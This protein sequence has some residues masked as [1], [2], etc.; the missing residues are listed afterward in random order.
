M[1]TSF[2]ILYP[3]IMTLVWIIG[4]VFYQ[5]SRSSSA[6]VAA[7]TVGVSVLVPCFNEQSHLAQ[8]V[9]S[10]ADQAHQNLEVILIDDASTDDTWQLMKQLQSDFPQLH[11]KTV[12]QRQN[13]GKAAALNAGLAVANHDYVLC[14][15]A[16]SRIE[17]SAT[18]HL[19]ATLAAHPDMGA[20]TGRP[21]VINR[22]R[23][24]EKMQAMEYIAIIDLIKRSQMFF[25]GNILTISGVL[26]MFRKDA[27]TAIN[28]WDP[29][30]QTEDIDI[31]WRLSQAGYCVGYNHRAI[32]WILVPFTLRALLKQR[33]R[34]AYGGLQV[35]LKHKRQLLRPWQMKTGLLYEMILSVFWSF[36]TIYSLI[37]FLVNIYLNNELHL[38]GNIILMIIVMGIFQFFVGLTLSKKIC[39]VKWFI[40]LYTP[41]YIFFYWAIN[42]VALLGAVFKIVY[43]PAANGQWTSPSREGIDGKEVS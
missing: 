25:T 36:T 8:T 29:T 18:D 22:Q 16:D 31:T 40:Y 27:V 15:D 38:D 3:L 13:Q 39:Q 35:L 1:L 30:V 42:L 5:L 19:L 10:L 41:L 37:F 21:Q 24:I 23:L 17:A 6:K 11:I 32:T 43:L 14:I 34:W 7:S 20:V 28:G 26:A 33:R 4:T 2:I 12:S 9:R